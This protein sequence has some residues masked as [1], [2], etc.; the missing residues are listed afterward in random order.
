MSDLNLD[1]YYD[2]VVYDV[3]GEKV[4]GVGQVFLDEETGEPSWVTVRTGLFGLKE[5]FVPLVESRLEDGVLHVK[6]TKEFIKE[7][8]RQDPDAPM[9]VAEEDAL[10][11]HYGTENEPDK[12]EANMHAREQQF[13]HGS[14]PADEREFA[15]DEAQHAHRTHDEHDTADFGEHRP[16]APAEA[17]GD[18]DVTPAGEIEPSAE[19]PMPGHVEHKEPETVVYPHQTDFAEKADADLLAETTDPD[20]D[21]PALAEDRDRE[22]PVPDED[23]AVPL[24]D[25][26]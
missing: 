24:D 11:A 3:N 22:R 18:A 19:A 25:E 21:R 17:A 14:A 9:T 2:A 1:E 13:A 16:V 12:M 6:F 8:P 5:S 26:R 23:R 20:G 15:R 10:Q 7:A 4:G